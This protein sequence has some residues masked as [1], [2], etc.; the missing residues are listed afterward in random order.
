MNIYAPQYYKEF[1]CIAGLCRH[2]CCAGW[3]I[4][5]DDASLRRYRAMKGVF[6]DWLNANI[7]ANDV[8][9]FI[10][11][12]DERCPLLNDD[13]LCK[14]I[15]HCGEESLC[16]I[17]ADHPRF[18]NYWSGRIEIGLGMVCEEA[19]RIIL[20]ENEPMR[21]ERIEGSEAENCTEAEEYLFEVRET[22]L[23][24]IRE[25]GPAAR[26]KEYL[27]FRHLA[28]ALYD[29]R[30]EERI[31]F[32]ENAYQCIIGKWNDG[33]IESLI[34]LSRR[35]SDTIEYDDDKLSAMIDSGKVEFQ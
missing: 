33:K 25:V 21:I 6:A 3:E 26:L 32:I 10:L 2:T 8:P 28:D 12:D 1:H 34:E 23:T 9:H 22:L 18:R 13:N 11:T 24:N 27:I 14:L 20:S 7:A 19:A 15:L 17:C 5:I 16:Q 4:D 30:L 31:I 35:F 29:N